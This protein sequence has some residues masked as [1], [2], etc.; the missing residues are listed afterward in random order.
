ML[1]SPGLRYFGPDP[2]SLFPAPLQTHVLGH[3]RC[4]R[5]HLVVAV[6]LLRQIKISCLLCAT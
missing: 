4:R 5:R 1:Y 6:R 2:S 3:H